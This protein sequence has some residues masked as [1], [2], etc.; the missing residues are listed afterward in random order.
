MKKNSLFK[1][2]TAAAL[3][4]TL[5]FSMT[6][7]P[8]FAENGGVTFIADDIGG[9][10]QSDIYY[11][12]NS[13]TFSSQRFAE[14]RVIVKLVG[15]LRIGPEDAQ[16]IW[17]SWDAY[18][19]PDLGVSFTDVRLLNP[20]MESSNT[21]GFSDN[22]IQAPA[23]TFNS[24]F[25]TFNSDTSA[26]NNVFV[27]TLEETGGD[28]VQNA[29]AILNANPAVEIAEPD[30]LYELFATPNDPM[31]DA[32]YALKRI[33]AEPAWNVTTGS[34]SVVVG[35]V[36]S[37]I[38]GTHLDLADDLWVNPCPGQSG[39]KNDIHGYDFTGRVG[40][41]PTDVNGHGT[42]VAGIIG[43][44]GNNG[45]GISGV[46]WNVSLA[47]LGI[48]EGGNNVSVS[49]AIEAINYANNHNIPILNNS[50]GGTI[51]SETLRQAI[52][53]YNGLFVA[54][55]GNDGADNDTWPYY[56]ASYDLPNVISVASTDA[57]D[58]LSYFSNY[59][60]N[61]VH[62]AAPGSDILGAYPGD[63]YREMSGTSMAS[64]HVAGVAA[65]IKAVNPDYPPE[66]IREVLLA[67][68]RRV[69]TLA[70]YDFGIV[71]A[72]A[73]VRF[74]IGDLCTVTFDFLDD[75][76]A[77]V[78]VMVAP[79]GRLR[80]PAEPA[81]DGY[82]FDGW[83]TQAQ[84]GVPYDFSDAVNGDMTLYA[85]WFVPEPGMYYWEFPDLNFQ[86][87]VLRLL[88]DQYGGYRA[89]SSIVA[90]DEALLASF[91]S[92]DVSNRNIID[93][94]GLRY[95]TGLTWLDC[96]RNRLTELD[97]SSN[98]E[99]TR[100]DCSDNEL[101]ELNV[102]NN[103]RLTELNGSYNQMASPGSIIGWQEIGLVLDADFI[104]YPQKTAFTALQNE[105]AAY[106][107]AE[108][109]IVVTICADVPMTSSLVVPGNSNGKTL[110]I[111][112]DNNAR[113][114]VRSRSH[115]DVL[116]VNAGASVILENITIDGNKDAYPDNLSPLVYVNGGGLILEDGA[117]LANNGG[118]MFDGGGVYVDTGSFTMNGGEISGNT[119][120]DFFGGGGGVYAWNGAFTM[121]GGEISGN[122]ALWYGGGVY[123]AATGSFAMNGGKIS[124]NTAISTGGGVYA[125]NNSMF[126][127][128][129]GEITGN[130]AASWGGGGVHA[131]VNNG[132]GAVEYGGVFILGGT[133]VIGGNTNS[134]VYL[135][136]S[137]NHNGAHI[138]LGDGPG[139]NGVAAPAVGMMVGVTKIGDDNVIVQSGASP[140]A[141][142]YF[143]TDEDDGRVTYEDGRLVIL[144][145]YNLCI[146]G[147]CLDGPSDITITLD[148][149][150]TLTSPV[151]VPPRTKLAVKSAIAASPVTLTRGVYD[152][153]FTVR[154]GAK[155]I[156]E[157]I[158]IDG[159]KDAYHD[160]ESSLVHVDGGEFTMKDGAVLTNNGGNIYYSDGGVFVSSGT[161]IMLG[162][163]IRDNIAAFGGGV[164]VSPGGRFT[165]FGG[166]IRDN[167]A[168]SGGGVYIDA[169]IDS[170]MEGDCTFTMFDGKISSNTAEWDYGG[171]VYLSSGTFTM[172]GGEIRDNIA[173]FGG[174]VLLDYTYK[175]FIV[176]GTAVI[177]GNT[178]N[179]VYLG[180][181]DYFIKLSTD[182]PPAPGMEVWVT[183]TGGD[184]VIVESGTSPG[185]AAYFFADESG[186]MVVHR[187]D[188]LIIVDKTFYEPESIGVT[189]LPSKTVYIVGETLNL[190]G[191]VVTAIYGDGITNV[192]TG[193][194]A[195]PADGGRLDAIGRQT[196]T[197]GYEGKTAGFTVTVNDIPGAGGGYVY[198][199]DGVFYS[200]IDK[201]LWNIPDNT[202]AAVKLLEDVDYP[203]VIDGK[204]ITFDL[205]GYD[206]TGGIQAASGG[207]ITLNGDVYGEV[208]A[209]G[210]GTVVN[211]EGDAYNG[212]SAYDGGT[213][214][215]SGNVYG[216]VMVY[217][218]GTVTIDGTLNVENND[219]YVMIDE[220]WLGKRGGIP[221]MIKSGYIEYTIDGTS[222]VWVN[223]P[224][225]IY[226]DVN[227][228]GAVNMQDLTA[229]AQYLARWP[230]IVI[231]E[232][233]ADVDN[234]GRVLMPDLTILSRHL[235][236]WPG[237]EILPY[238]EPARAAQIMP[239]QVSGIFSVQP[240]VPAINIS[241]A[242]GNVRDI[243][244]VNIGLAGNPGIIAMRL[245]VEFDDSVLRLID[246]VDEGKLGIRYH[247]DVYGASPHTLLWENG[248]SSSNFTYSGDVV[249]LRFEILSKTAD[250]PVTVNY[251]RADWDIFDFDLRPVYFE[252]NN[253]SISTPAAKET[254]TLV[255]AVASASV[256]K[257]N[258]NKNEL[259]VAVK[260]TFSDS[261]TNIIKE[262]F[263]IDNNAAGSYRVGRYTVYV[264]TKGN[265]QIRQCHIVN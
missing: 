140:A 178:D 2:I 5:I 15:D 104:F 151:T 129:D 115:T 96:S 246:V 101:T 122:N 41:I 239:A 193:Y 89:R 82:A 146:L 49:A 18:L 227:G 23:Q 190:T 85:R 90:S 224:A 98:T 134:N 92:L 251:G 228:D 237:Y 56:P 263:L 24:Q 47:W 78:F 45:T 195:N 44:K 214:N 125:A 173:S 86:R 231:D 7:Y 167:A 192:V 242:S 93:I 64:P 218:G 62:I 76:T 245:G 253:G 20:S 48:H 42:H 212:V 147:Y 165:M 262:T 219:Y 108:E 256:K 184:D 143:F 132:A 197:V 200:S 248:A 55:A 225:I 204:T 229:L 121:N 77:P 117:V 113:A 28:A 10:A 14:D 247:R 261:T 50:W 199:M 88:N 34:M 31:F 116:V 75:E 213:V 16:S 103:T 159:S 97:I 136:G 57:E 254:V 172:L 152:S 255:G 161:F 124:D 109:D 236:R 65:L 81:R 187:T 84:G 73:A 133:A 257:L 189:T 53:G 177:S 6:P 144:Y 83:Y 40:G 198:E 9:Y 112:G 138:T 29:V 221:S 182:T 238:I 61:S 107:D 80:E 1:M 4:M 127:M 66:L 39:Y 196:V 111:T 169:Y 25:S 203:L 119:A 232:T 183:K 12:E 120:G 168:L 43:A 114:L 3:S 235:A 210:D 118:N 13:T 162:G 67:S 19:P 126:T 130:T 176:G 166:E 264:D 72:D 139:G 211:V 201:V 106:G 148:E 102:T 191:M 8:A 52:S 69:D 37:G 249:T 68:A 188:Q 60:V 33:N 258:G 79:G 145:G 205:N 63:A 71:D 208:A 87:E 110:T 179:N 54:A 131:A 22:S 21:G 11:A 186:R 141:A 153:L 250:S 100:L 59:G 123:I 35:V 32:Q 171:G 181:D 158:I 223:T 180:N 46:N 233:A 91:A 222:T 99:L 150:L 74:D 265:D 163:E 260:E 160:N 30:F 170:G 185:D 70:W 209:Y 202:P 95:F 220:Q 137:I 154:N 241:S 27:L 174:G 216:S 252:V 128:Q 164:L 51:Y 259:T 157:D 149:D 135:D 234:D 215:I 94:T 175:E 226:G 58:D 217:T 240:A 194:A 105:I 142:E 230:G 243:V 156:L 26:Q 207:I 36:D 206:L 155:L 17:G 244:D 38:D